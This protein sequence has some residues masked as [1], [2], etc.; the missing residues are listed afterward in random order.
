M[1][2]LFGRPDG[3]H[4]SSLENPSSPLALYTPD[5]RPHEWGRSRQEC[6]RHIMRRMP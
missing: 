5:K 3:A 4:S 6:L 2:T 1:P